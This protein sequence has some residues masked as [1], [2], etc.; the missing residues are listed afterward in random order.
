MTSSAVLEILKL[1]GAVAFGGLAGQLLAEYFRRRGARVQTLTLIERVNREVSPGLKG[2]TLA[3]SVAAGD[4]TH[5][6]PLQDL[7]EYQLTLRNSSSLHLQNVEVQ[8]E[9]PAEDVES[10]ASRPARSQTALIPVNAIANDPWKKAFRWQIPQ[11]PAGDS[12]EFTFQAVAP[13]SDEYVVALYNAAGAV[14]EKVKGEPS[15]TGINLEKL[16][17]PLII[18]IAFV[19][20]LNAVWWVWQSKTEE[21]KLQSTLKNLTPAARTDDVIA[22][23]HTLATSGCDLR[24]MSK[25]NPGA[26]SSFPNLWL[27]KHQVLNVGQKPCTF[28]WKNVF[29]RD[30]MEPG[31]ISVRYQGSNGKPKPS[32]VQ[33]FIFDMSSGPLTKGAADNGLTKLSSQS[34]IEALIPAVSQQ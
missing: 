20:T 18:C 1:I 7:R 34:E 10:W 28:E 11:L 14:I 33:I 2:I 8:F 25:A 9:F 3:R 24:I 15:P 23:D 16:I 30:T 27:I 31:G 17:N 5:L 4:T 6:E 26:D 21:S 29:S 19:T 22:T 32:K 13:S 12:V